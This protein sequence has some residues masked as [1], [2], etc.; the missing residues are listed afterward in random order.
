MDKK[1]IKIDIGKNKVV[2]YVAEREG[3]P[4]L[5]HSI[6]IKSLMSLARK[7]A[8]AL[9]GGQPICMELLKKKKEKRKNKI[10]KYIKLKIY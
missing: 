2:K 3:R 6:A 7:H 8:S 5:F 10:V 4:F 9:G 1:W